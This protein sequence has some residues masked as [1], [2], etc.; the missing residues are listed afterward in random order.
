MSLEQRRLLDHAGSTRLRVGV[1]KVP[2]VSHDHLPR[3]DYVSLGAWKRAL[4]YMEQKKTTKCMKFKLLPLTIIKQKLMHNITH[5]MCPLR[6]H[7]ATHGKKGYNFLS[8]RG[9]GKFL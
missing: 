6:E 8:A 4:H 7:N 3:D 5:K 2:A 9:G 1:W